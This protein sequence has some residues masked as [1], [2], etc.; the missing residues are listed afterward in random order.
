MGASVGCEYGGGL[1]ASRWDF[2]ASL[3]EMRKGI[4][5][6]L[7]ETQVVL[8]VGMY[9]AVLSQAV[10]IAKDQWEN[11]QLNS[12]SC[13]L[14]SA[15]LS[16]LWTE[17]FTNLFIHGVKVLIWVLIWHVYIPEVSTSFLQPQRYWKWCWYGFWDCRLF[18]LISKMWRCWNFMKGAH[19]LGN[20]IKRRQRVM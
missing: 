3:F 16:I 4:C 7:P 1:G 2:C 14:P 13:L 19:N 18:S 12:I 11:C 20:G 5:I 9:E 15:N 10:C 8:M 6:L 17:I